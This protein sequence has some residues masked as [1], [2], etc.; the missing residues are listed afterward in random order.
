MKITTSTNNV[1]FCIKLYK[2]DQ[3]EFLI[4]FSLEDLLLIIIFAKLHCKIMNICAYEDTRDVSYD[5]KII[6]IR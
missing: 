4:Y 1:A 3:K 6:V 5:I 2:S